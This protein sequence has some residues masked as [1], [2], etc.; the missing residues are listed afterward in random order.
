M[1]QATAALNLPRII[2]AIEGGQ[3]RKSWKSIKQRP[4]SQRHGA[5]GLLTTYYHIRQTLVI[6]DMPGPLCP[7]RWLNDMKQQESL[8]RCISITCYISFLSKFDYGN[9]K[10]NND[11]NEN[12]MNYDIFDFG[13]KH[14]V[15]NYLLVIRKTIRDDLS[16]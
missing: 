9:H 16:C 15:C 12:K 14:L 11:K 8:K 7:L 13:Q 3:I 1:S 4:R 10:N 5:W 2:I 6:L